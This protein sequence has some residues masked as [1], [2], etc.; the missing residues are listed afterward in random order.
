[1][2]CFR[3]ILTL[4]YST[5]LLDW[6]LKVV[7]MSQTATSLANHSYPGAWLEGQNEL[8]DMFFFLLFKGI[9]HSFFKVTYRGY[10]LLAC[11]SI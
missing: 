1:M 4:K 9:P 6:N 10:D 7:L 3:S 8:L 11:E 2:Q 5:V